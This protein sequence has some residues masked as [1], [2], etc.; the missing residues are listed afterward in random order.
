MSM[1]DEVIEPIVKVVPQKPVTSG[2]SD[3]KNLIESVHIMTGHEP[4]QE[5]PIEQEQEQELEQEVTCFKCVGEK[6]NKRGKPCKKCNGTGL[7]RSNEIAQVISVVRGEI[8]EYCNNTFTGLIKDYLKKKSEDQA[9]TEHPQIICDA[10]EMDP[11]KGIRFKCS[12]CPD[13]DLC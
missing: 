9:N 13:Y 7:I 2:P 1:K 10:C 6:F 5:E 12:V 3:Q 4:K 8:K 11:V